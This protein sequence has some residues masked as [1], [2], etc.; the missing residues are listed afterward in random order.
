[1]Q[2]DLR[3]SDWSSVIFASLGKV[4][5]SHWRGRAKDRAVREAIVHAVNQAATSTEQSEDWVRRFAEL[6]KLACDGTF[7][8]M[9]V[10]E[11]KKI[12][13]S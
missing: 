4:V 9:T 5:P 2:V 3:T 7:H 6:H 12:L 11:I 8:S 13:Q 10:D 1:M